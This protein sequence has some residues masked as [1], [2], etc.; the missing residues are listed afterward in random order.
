MTFCRLQE[1]YESPFEEI[2]GKNFRIF[3][4]MRM[5]S[6]KN[7][8]G[9]FTYANDWDGFNV[10]SDAI[11]SCYVKNKIKD[12]NE[13]DKII[14]KIHNDICDKLT[15]DTN[16]R[17]KYYLIGTT[18]KDKS[19]MLHEV[20]HG[21]YNLNKIFKEKSNKIIDDIPN[22]IYN[23]MSKALKNIGYSDKTLKDEINA[24]LST[25]YDSIIH[26]EEF[27]VKEEERIKDFSKLLKDNFNTF[28]K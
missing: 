9:C 16:V 11:Y 17:P 22:K 26:N 2:R 10:P 12:L 24:Y 7:G 8:D 4:F 25:G 28:N 19:A 15:D 3:D 6:K 5:Y 23:K 1:F 13:Y 14:Q 18:G 21:M 20:C 27:T